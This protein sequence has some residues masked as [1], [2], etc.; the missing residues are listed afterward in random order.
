ML[1][2]DVLQV[3]RIEIGEVFSTYIKIFNM[4]RDYSMHINW[5]L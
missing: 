1:I 3:I 2:T 5:R 4:T